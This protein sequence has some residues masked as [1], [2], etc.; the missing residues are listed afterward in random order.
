MFRA[1]VLI[2]A[3]AALC[4]GE[5]YRA[6]VES[7]NRSVLSSE[8]SAKVIKISYKNG[9]KFDKGSTLIE[10]DCSLIKTQKEKIE[11]E[12]SGLN[13]KY[14]S[15]QKMAKLNAIGELEVNMALSELRQKEAERKMADISVSKCEVKA[16]YEGKVQKTLIR[17]YEYV[18]E[19][20]ELMEIVGTRTLELDILIPARAVS[21][22]AVGK[23]VYFVSDETRQHAEG[24]VVGINPAT[25][26]ISQT[27]RI[28]AKLT[29]FSQYVMP[30]TVG[31]VRFG[32]K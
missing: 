21:S 13:A 5:S 31:S 25:D 32:N 30:G 10:Y 29:N 15:Y 16:P 11:A 14:E 4:A 20:K 6:I 24:T 1:A 8:I 17:E 28:R 23:K 26:P 18:G 22:I 27:I 2:T 12:L 7:P 3:A 19:Q 9:E